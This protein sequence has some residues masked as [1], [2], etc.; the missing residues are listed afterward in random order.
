MN[1]EQLI[2]NFINE[3]K[4]LP[5]QRSKEWIQLRGTR[6]G[7]SEISNIINL[8]P[9]NK[10]TFV[11]N[12]LYNKVIQKPNNFIF[13]CLHGNLFEPV[14]T[15]LTEYNYNTKIYETGSIPYKSL[16]CIS[17]SPDGI[18]VVN[19]EIVLFEFKCPLTRE[20]TN[21]LKYEY[22]CQVH[23]GLHV[24][25]EII[26][27]DKAL[28]I[29]A[30]FKKCNFLDLLN[31]DVFDK[32]YHNKNLNRD[33][34]NLYKHFGMIL[35][36]EEENYNLEIKDYGDATYAEIET[37][38]FNIFKKNFKPL[39]LHDVINKLIKNGDENYILKKYTNIN[40]TLFDIE[41]LKYLQSI[42][43]EE[44]K[45]NNYIPIG[46]LNYKCYNYNVIEVKKIDNFLN[47]E[48]KERCIYFSHIVKYL[49]F[50]KENHNISNDDV[51]KLLTKYTD[52]YI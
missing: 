9:T 7:G 32:E 25:E 26:T 8:K 3:W 1:Q 20:I 13:P 19:D 36:G 29:E 28:Y 27:S 18:G 11:N 42:L 34:N 17:Y 24:L 46:F 41:E 15:S 6:W 52:L 44:C 35:F 21:K 16:K 2:K 12:L 48:I 40:K 38:Y 37:L 49:K 22:Y 45:K 33:F 50:L 31:Y 5:E 23:T 51:K 4:H 14:I 10:T 30:E 39:Y 47:K 43:L